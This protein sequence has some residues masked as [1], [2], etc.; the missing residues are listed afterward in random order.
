MISAKF[1]ISNREHSL[2]RFAG[3]T[4]VVIFYPGYIDAHHSITVTG[5]H[6]ENMD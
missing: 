4:D 2:A 3:A 5:Q 6:K 1:S